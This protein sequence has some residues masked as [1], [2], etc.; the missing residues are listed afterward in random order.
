MA[1]NA[2][3]KKSAG[4]TTASAPRTTGDEKS[5]ILKPPP[6]AKVAIVEFLDLQCPDCARAAPLVKDVSKAENIPVV[7]YDFPL[8]MHNW[9]F[10]AA[11]IARYL[12]AKSKKV[13]EEWRRSCF[14]G[15]SPL[16]AFK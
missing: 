7:F 5:N 10:Q 12:D 3:T 4:K 16:S 1:K 6:G 9:S 15:Q 8:P 14:F 11:V 2:T 13:G